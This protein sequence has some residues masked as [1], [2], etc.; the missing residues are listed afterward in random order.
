VYIDIILSL[1]SIATV[2]LVL[3]GLALMVYI[4][5]GL[6]RAGLRTREGGSWHCPKCDYNL[7]GLSGS[8]CPECGTAA[9]KKTAE[10]G[11]LRP[12]WGVVAIGVVLLLAVISAIVQYATARW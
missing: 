11:E 4:G 9:T 2:I 5:Y 3:G 1:R 7:K 6:I 8:I 12:M 10:L